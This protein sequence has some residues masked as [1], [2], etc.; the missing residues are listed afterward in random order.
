MENS[1]GIWGSSRPK[2]SIRGSYRRGRT[3][4]PH[5]CFK[6]P[7]GGG[8]T[9]L[10][11]AAL[12]QLNR[13]TGLVLWITPTRAIY[14]Q[15]KDAFKNRE[16]P[17]RNMLE[18]ASGGRVMLM[19]KDHQVTY[20]DLVNYLCVMLLMLPAANRQKGR[21]FLRMFRDSGRYPTLFPESDDPLGDG[22][23]LEQYPDL[24]RQSEGGPVMHSLFNV[25]KMQRPVVVL[26]EAHKAYGQA[27]AAREFVQS[28]N[29]LDPRMVIELSAT[30]NGN[31]SNLLVDISG[32]EL[33]Q[34]Q[35]IKLPVQVKSTAK[36][37]AEWQYTL[38][39]AHE[40]LESISTEATSFQAS[41]GRYI[42]PI[43]VVR[44]ERTGRDQRDLDH[45][46]AEDVREYLTTNLGVAEK[47][48]RVK[49]SENDE[50]GRENLLSEHS[51]VRWIITKS[52]LMEGWDCSF[53]YVLVM[54][55]NT[56][57]QRAIT[58][59]V[60]RV[61]RQPNA[62]RTN[63]EKLD[64]CYVYCRNT[65]V[66]VAVQRVRDGLE[67][68]GLN[69]LG[70]LV[71][72]P[73][74]EMGTITLQ[75]REKY[76]E[77]A[78]FLPMV[79]HRHGDGWRKLDFEGHILPEVDWS[80]IGPPDIQTGLATRAVMQ[81][82]T[83]HL[84][85]EPPVFHP[86]Q[87]LY[88][89]KT[90]RISW[91]AR[92][93]AGLVT[94]P[95]QAA[96]IVQE[97]MARLRIEGHDDDWIYGQRSL[98]VTSL[99]EHVT[100]EIDKQTKKVFESKLKDGLIDFSLEAGR[101]KYEMTDTYPVSVDSDAHRYWKP[102]QLSLFEP[103]YPQQFDTGLERNFAFYLDEHSALQWWHRVAAR[104]QEGYYIRGWKRERIWPDFVAFGGEKGGQTSFLVFET[105]GDHLREHEDTKYKES[106][107]E[108]LQKAFNGRSLN[109]GK[110]TVSEG[111]AA[112]VFR[113]V[114]EKPGFPDAEEAFA[115]IPGGY[116]TG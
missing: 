54:L 2:G 35:M 24:E 91:F 5:A 96:R 19:E 48:V 115:L 82:A 108:A 39:Q 14:Q 17:Y 109:A 95:W 37:V 104:Q 25:F 52:A 92:R 12:R 26:D 98:L 21:E 78:I 31:I 57:A 4:D 46:H 44:V 45:V 53:A 69:G 113:L 65:E 99:R 80:I 16:H 13:Q 110:V 7:T 97:L 84:G 11:T 6:I 50:L 111:P 61:M 23:L 41:E 73:S 67:Q 42:R 105:K 72:G 106:V 27:T 79:N 90:V 60:G 9:L 103:V 112:G 76:Q 1:F 58:Q 93:L 100:R 77:Q 102:M 64:Q 51:P 3:P 59:L 47:A 68:E 85:S 88:I 28:V 107:F 83:V 71:L 62:T 18:E 74:T 38:S 8:K 36:D 75:R 89:D 86:D 63:R 22:R 49:S 20:G 114:F 33:Y 101:V 10:G 66:G 34:E 32:M 81:S 94:N 56:Q 30:P 55:D 29:R 116:T 87:D 70:N 43:A 40:E 15:T